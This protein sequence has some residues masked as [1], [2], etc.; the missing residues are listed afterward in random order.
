MHDQ[1]QVCGFG[2]VELFPQ[3]ATP[4]P[5]LTKP[6]RPAAA[7]SLRNGLLRHPDRVS[8]LLLRVARPART[9]GR[10]FIPFL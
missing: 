3:N 4:L 10:A 8:E 6:N 2:S 1:R 9:A 7:R 5:H